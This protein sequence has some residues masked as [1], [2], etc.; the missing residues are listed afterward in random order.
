MNQFIETLG[1]TG[2]FA[3]AVV[4][5]IMILTLFYK[6]L[7]WLGGTGTAPEALAVRGV[8]KKDTWATVRLQGGQTFDHVRFLGYTDATAS[9]AQVP[10][11]L[12]GMVIL[13]DE[14]QR[15]YLIRA[16]SIHMITIPPDS[17]KAS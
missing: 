5:S 13:E 8:L 12:S 3:I 6:G 14:Q 9:K 1:A 16:K 4:A 11:D 7:A 17:P 10:W 2:G 15:R